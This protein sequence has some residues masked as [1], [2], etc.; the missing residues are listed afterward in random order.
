MHYY[1]CSKLYEGSDDQNN[2]FQIAQK[3]FENIT[4]FYQLTKQYYQKYEMPVLG[5]EKLT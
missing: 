3:F 1:V 2:A 5:G 4:K